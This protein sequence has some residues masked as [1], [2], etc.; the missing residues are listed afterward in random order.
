MRNLDTIKQ[1][2]VND[3][4][5]LRQDIRLVSGDPE[6][7]VVVESTAPL[8]YQY[9]ILLEFEDRT[10][11]LDEFTA[12]I[13]DDAFK[14]TMVQAMG[15]QQSGTPYTID[16]INTMISDRL[17]AYVADFN[18]IRSAGNAATGFVTIY[19]S[20]S[21]TVSWN[22]NTTFT[23][24]TGST[25]T[26]TSAVSNVVPNFNTT[27]G[28]YYVTIPVQST[29]TGQENNA[30]AG[31]IRAVSPK[32]AS[33]SYCTNESAIDGALDAETD[34]DLIDR[35]KAAWANRVNGS[36]GAL[37]QLA[38]AQSYVSDVLAMD[39]D[40]EATGIYIGSVID[41]FTQFVAED[42]ELVEE[43]VYWPGEAGNTSAESFDFTP[44]H[45][46]LI[47]DISPIAFVYDL[48]DNESQVVPGTDSITGIVTS[49]G[50]VKDTNTYSEST[51]AV[52]KIR[53]QMV[54]NTTNNARKIKLLYVYDKSPYKLQAVVDDV[55]N[56]MVGPSP[57][58]RKAVE[59]PI[60]VIAE[61]TTSF[62]FDAQAVQTAVTANIGMYFSGG[63]TSYGKQFERKNIGDPVQHTDIGT[64]ILKTPGVVA[65]DTDTF[66]VIN[67]LTGDYTDPILIKENQY[68]SLFD[69]QYTFNTFNLANFTASFTNP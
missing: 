10:R 13:S 8:F 21:S 49:V 19:L 15:L 25:Y 33:F 45:Q 31:A 7:D 35:A 9:E 53:I 17:N 56:R 65:Y 62:G 60:R 41:L 30:T 26:A 6:Y 5:A 66:Y 48:S 42:T 29:T 69:V 12:L 52:D 39:T 1:Q 58:V 47:S 50:I 18:I 54:L 24:G 40:D 38:R 2:I 68:A 4:L 63:T 11:N 34:L 51:K 43:Y 36:V 67:T 59:V 44:M 28:L 61:L 16:S 3:I 64:I 14:T 23:S 37:E 55:A 57:L 27:K 46:P 22:S 32:P 20:D